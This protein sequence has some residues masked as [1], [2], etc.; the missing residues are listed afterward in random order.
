MNDNNKDKIDNDKNKMRNSE[1]Y[2]KEN[3]RVRIYFS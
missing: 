1:K 2:I 3:K